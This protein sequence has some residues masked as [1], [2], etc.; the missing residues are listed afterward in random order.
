MVARYAYL[1]GYGLVDMLSGKSAGPG[2]PATV[3]IEAINSSLQVAT[4]A[5][6]ISREDMWDF[7]GAKYGS[8]SNFV[9]TSVVQTDGPG[10]VSSKVLNQH[11]PTNGGSNYAADP[12]GTGIT[13]SSTPLAG[14]PVTEATIEYDFRC[15]SSGPNPWGWG[16]KL[17]GLAG[18][19][20]GAGGVPG[21]GSPSPNG[22]SGRLMFRGTSAR[23]ETQARLVGYVYDPTQGTNGTVYGQDRDT[24]KS[25]KANTWHHLKQQYVMNSI[26]TEGSVGNPDGI[27][28]I[29][30]D[31]VLCWE[32]KTQVYRLFADA[33]ITHLMWDNFY[34]G[35]TAAWGPLID[36]DHQF[37]NL[38]VTTY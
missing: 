31:G 8:Y 21:G 11:F 28:R 25:L 33:K 37:D 7:V 12:T 4:L 16:G 20:P 3:G 23:T 36:V 2:V 32:S 9:N 34:G 10:G 13:L 17:P 27:H 6:P 15:K 24:G 26:A 35:D 38:V 14:G 30:L 19:K 29:W 1:N 18:V 5:S 22:W